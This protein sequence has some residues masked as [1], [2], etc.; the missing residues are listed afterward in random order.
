MKS[1]RILLTAILLIVICVPCEGLF[2]ASTS[3]Q[4]YVESLVDAAKFKFEGIKSLNSTTTDQ[5][6]SY[7]KLKYTRHYSSSG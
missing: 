1:Y 3:F 7:F 6:W 2:G 4:D 5:I